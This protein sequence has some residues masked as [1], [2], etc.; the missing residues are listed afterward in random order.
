MKKVSILTMLPI[1]SLAD[2]NVAGNY[3]HLGFGYKK[4]IILLTLLIHIPNQ[5]ED[6]G[7]NI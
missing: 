2:S 6:A 3:Y 7:F 1:A 5:L 4:L